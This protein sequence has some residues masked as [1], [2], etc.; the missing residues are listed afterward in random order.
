LAKS[1]AHLERAV[2]LNPY[3]WRYRR[4]L[5]RLYE[6]AGLL[7]D[8]EAAFSRA[9]E[10][11]PRSGSYR[12]RLANFYLRSGSLDRALVQ[13]KAAVAADPKLL[14]AAA[15]LLLKSGASSQQILELWPDD[16]AAWRELLLT[17]SRLPASRAAI[18][19]IRQAAWQRSLAA[20]EPLPLADGWVTIER[21]ITEGR[22]L[23]A[24]RKWGEL[25]DRNAM[26]DAELE[27]ERTWVWNGAFERPL[28]RLGLG[29]QVGSRGGGLEVSRVD[30]AGVDGSAALQIAFDGSQNLSF[31]GVR[32]HLVVKPDRVYRFSCRMR[33]EELSTD[34]GAF[35][36][37]VDPGENRIVLATPRVV[38]STPWT[39]YGGTFRLAEGSS[40]VLLRLSRSPSLRFEPRLQGTLWIDSV[41]LEEG[42][43]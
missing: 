18:S 24:R 3:S 34:Q 37:V 16:P 13:V 4:E 35:W 10:M 15:G 30:G 36:E 12:W 29:W 19:E 39:V 40:R 25:A 8:A 21:L 20:P 9:V 38:G 6:Q 5:A 42:D 7:E 33:S 41:R 43:S 32:Q 2:E 22:A 31:L 28:T 27:A 17:A 1:R 14:P 26:G 23:E 11:N